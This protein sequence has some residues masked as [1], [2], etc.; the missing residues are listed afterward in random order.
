[1]TSARV[2]GAFKAGRQLGHSRLQTEIILL[3]VAQEGGNPWRALGYGVC[4]CSR[5][6]CRTDRLQ[7]V[8]RIIR[9][10]IDA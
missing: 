6:E 4:G 2:H 7:Y 10:E 3:D 9:G 1:M 8:E 5:E